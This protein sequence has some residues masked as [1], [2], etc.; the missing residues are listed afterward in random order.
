VVEDVI[1]IVASFACGAAVAV[2]VFALRPSGSLYRWADRR[3]DDEGRWWKTSPLV[4]LAYIATFPRGSF[5]A[6]RRRSR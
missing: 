1:T 2:V 3:V 6:W 5:N 4:A